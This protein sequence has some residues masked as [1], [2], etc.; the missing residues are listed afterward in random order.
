MTYKDEIIKAMR[1][2][3]KDERTIF[4][5]QSVAY[6]GSAI[7][8]TCKD[9]PDSKKIE[10]PLIEDTQMGMSI[11]LSLE[12]YIPVSIYP[13]FDFLILATNQLVNH[14]DKIEDMSLGQFKPRVIIR[15]VVGSTDP[16]YP[17]AQHC[18]DYTE[19]FEIML[20]NINVVKLTKSK[21]IVP[22][23]KNAL[24][25]KDEKSTLLIEVADLYTV[26]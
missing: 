15:T 14:L 26:D 16:L 7:Y 17:G 9:I 8:E 23:Y 24:V 1:L 21:D 3:A 4:L 2:L 5:G 20:K 6:P 10:L 13:R 18:S 19:A 12:G 25:A 22:S 11:G